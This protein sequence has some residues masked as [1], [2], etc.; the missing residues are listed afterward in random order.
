MKSKKQDKELKSTLL[1][2]ANIGDD[3]FDKMIKELLKNEVT[4]KSFINASLKDGVST[5]EINK[6]LNYF[7]VKTLIT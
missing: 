5:L 2:K 7:G 3:D 4:L 6:Q 1:G